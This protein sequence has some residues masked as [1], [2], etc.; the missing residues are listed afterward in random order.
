MS[1]LNDMLRDLSRQKPVGDGVEAYDNA[2]L[3]T[4][5]LAPRKQPSW[6]P[7]VVFFVV[8]FCIVLMAKRYLSSSQSLTQST[9]AH[10]GTNI[11]QEASSVASNNS[12]VTPAVVQANAVNLDA[13]SAS[14][15]QDHI[16]DLLNQA[17]RAISMD[18]L[19]VPIEDNAY[20]YYQK[21]LVLSP[22]N[23][24]AKEGLDKIAS[25][26]MAMAQDQINA[27][28]LQQAQALIQRARFVSERY[29]QAHEIS[30]GEVAAQNLGAVASEKIN[31]EPVI[32]ETIK[33]IPEAEAQSL[34]VTPNAAW[35]DEQLAK[36]AQE[37]AQQGKQ[38][39]ALALLKSFVAAEQ[40]PILSAALLADLYIQQANTQ[41]ATIVL[42]KATYL[43][44]DI[45][46]KLHAQILVQQGEESEAI[47]LLEKNIG[48]AQA[49]ESYGALL[50]SLYH[51]TANY[52]Q[53]ILSYRG[54][55]NHFGEKPAYWLGL[56]LAYDGL[57]QTKNALQAYK[58]L[59][60]F[61]QLQEQVKKYTDQRI[62]A[63]GG[64]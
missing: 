61:P 27:G 2:L 5:S 16:N 42:Q 7:F 35:K 45:S 44:I 31:A 17:E 60:E 39:E 46:T 54:L 20:N 21:I 25:R 15:N 9:L 48:S 19:T 37:L 33:S 55:L 23:N 64:E 63:L 56:A 24:Q 50:A 30:I 10:Q 57:G 58:R 34:S 59:G 41:A 6:V 18:R 8:I 49:N 28:N 4:S 40:K 26:Y 43:P 53:S 3:E 13:A 1:L 12:V 22:N 32:S 38:T 11:L 29:V 52:Q 62:A 51:K 47:S 36:H 14:E